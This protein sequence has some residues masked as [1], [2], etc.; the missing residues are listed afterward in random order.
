MALDIKASFLTLSARL[1]VNVHDLNNE[2]STGNVSDIRL[3]EYIGPDGKR[4]E[5]PGVSGRMIKHWHQEVLRDL[6]RQ[7]GLPL[8]EACAAGEPIRPGKWDP[9]KGQGG[10]Y[11]WDPKPEEEAISQCVICDVHGYLIAQMS[12]SEKE[13]G[14]SARRNSRA[15]FSWAIPVFGTE[16]TYRQVTHT[17]VSAVEHVGNEKSQAGQALFYKSYAS[18]EL[19]LVSALDLDNVGTVFGKSAVTADRQ[20]R[21]KAAIEAY[22]YLLSGRLGASMGHAVPHVDCRE[23]AVAVGFGIPLAIPPSPIFEGYLEK[24]VGMLPQGKAAVAHYGDAVAGIPDGVERVRSLD[25]LIE[26]ALSQL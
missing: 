1:L 9:K 12:G 18:E 8:C 10:A 6:A 3:I 7:L 22:R 14:I 17:R 21:L 20:E 19:G 5:A 16:P 13:K 15:L 11:T 4:I 25:A 23:V 26:W 24:L 2:A